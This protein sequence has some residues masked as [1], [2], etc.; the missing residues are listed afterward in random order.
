MHECSKLCNMYVCVFDGKVFGIGTI[1]SFLRSKTESILLSIFVIM[2]YL[3]RAD[4]NLYSV[5]VSKIYIKEHRK[6]TIKVIIM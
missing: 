6:V 5:Y 4:F 2:I 3:P 1:R